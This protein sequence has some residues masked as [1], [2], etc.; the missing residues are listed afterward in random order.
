MRDIRAEVFGDGMQ[1][2]G[3]SSEQLKRTIGGV[4]SPRHLASQLLA[5]PRQIEQGGDLLSYGI[6]DRHFSQARLCVAEELGV[7]Q[8]YS[9]LP[10]QL[11]DEVERSLIAP[12]GR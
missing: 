9:S 12:S 2:A 8:C 3:V 1:P 4:Q 7:F 10:G 11:A 6:Q 5:Q